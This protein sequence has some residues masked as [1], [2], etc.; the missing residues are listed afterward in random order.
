MF[1][2]IDELF[3]GMPY[4]FGIANGILIAGFDEKSKDHD[5]TLEKVL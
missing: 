2:K 5:D 1:Q 4:V 3:T